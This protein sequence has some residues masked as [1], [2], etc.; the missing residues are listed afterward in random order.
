[1]V[2]EDTDEVQV[3]VFIELVVD[4]DVFVVVKVEVDDEEEVVVDAEGLVCHFMGLM[5][6]Q[7]MLL[8]YTFL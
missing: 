4:V 7:R 3:L 8:R 1:V 6:L 5:C 2:V